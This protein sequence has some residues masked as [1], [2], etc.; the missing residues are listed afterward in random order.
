VF[1]AN[2]VLMVPLFDT[3]L[4]WIALG[5]R[6]INGT[7]VTFSDDWLE[8]SVFMRLGWACESI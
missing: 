5:V 2:R 4:T 3:N 1:G 7:D 8:I 6:S